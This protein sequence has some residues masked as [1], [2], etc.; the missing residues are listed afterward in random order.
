AHQAVEE[1]YRDHDEWITKSILNVA[2]MSKFSSD[3]SIQEYAEE[4][5]NIEPMPVDN[6]KV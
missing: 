4:V 6:S 3:R 1:A 2:R 5:W